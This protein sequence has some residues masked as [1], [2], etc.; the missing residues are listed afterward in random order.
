MRILVLCI[1]GKRRERN[2]FHRTDGSDTSVLS[3]LCKKESRD[4]L[5]MTPG[6]L[7]PQE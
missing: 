3:F 5:N 4:L 6:F 7:L 1:S 2:V